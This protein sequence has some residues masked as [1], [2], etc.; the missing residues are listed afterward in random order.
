MTRQLASLIKSNI[1][2]VD[3]LGI[4]AEQV[5]HLTL[6]EALADCKGMVT[7]GSSFHQS[8]SKYPKI[9]NKIYI[10]M[11][12]AGEMSGSLD[13]ILNRLAEFTEAQNELQSKVKSA[14]SY[15]LILLCITLGVLMVLFI[16]VIPKMVTIFESSPDLTL[17]LV[18][19]VII[20]ISNF[21]INYWFIVGLGAIAL[22]FIFKNW[23]KT[24]SGRAQWDKILLAFPLFGPIIKDGGHFSLHANPLYPAHRGSTHSRSPIHRKKC[25]RKHPH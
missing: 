7:E 10:S 1:P 11:C 15:P 25:G 19:V 5:D 14:L 6:K 23:K 8:L 20:A 12:Q 16:F 3:A 9:F 13:V 18:T 22:F 24:P 2:L 21:F 17:P 4:L